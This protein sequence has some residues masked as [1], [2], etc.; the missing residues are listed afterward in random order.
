[1]VTFQ[2]SPTQEHKQNLR[3]SVSLIFQVAYAEKDG[4]AKSSLSYILSCD[5]ESVKQSE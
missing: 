2:H 3:L 5:R 4:K 1:M